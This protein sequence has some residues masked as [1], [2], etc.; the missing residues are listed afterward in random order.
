[1]LLLQFWLNLKLRTKGIFIVAVPA[2]ATVLIAGAAYVTGS[3]ADRAVYG[4]NQATEARAGIEELRAEEVDASAA[5]RG[6]L[7]AGD[8]RLDRR[9]GA[10]FAVFEAT[11]RRLEALISGQPAQQ[12][13]LDRI[14]ALQRAR[15]ETIVAAVA[16]YQSG[17]L[18]AEGQRNEVLTADNERSGMEALIGA[19]LDE[20]KRLL[21]ERVARVRELRFRSSAVIAGCGL[22][23]VAAGWAVWMLFASGITVRIRR[24]QENVDRLATGASLDPGPEGRDEIGLLSEGV[25][26]TVRTLKMKTGAL[27]NA[28]HGIAQANAAGAFVSVNKACAELLGLPNRAPAGNLLSRLRPE[29]RPAVEQAIAAMRQ[30]GRGEVEAKVLRADGSAADVTIVFLPVNAAD[31]NN[32]YHV[33]LRDITAQ[34]KAEQELI[35]ARDAALAGGRAKTQFLARISHDIRTPLN[36]ILGSADLLSQTSLGPDQRE[37]VSMF[38]RNCRRLVALINDFLDFSRIEA[39][40][41]RVERVPFRVRQIVDDIARTFNESASRKGVALNVDIAPAVPDRLSGD[42]LRIQQVL[43]NLASNALKFIREGRVDIR[44]R[45]AG[46]EPCRYVRF[47][48]ADTGPGI[49]PADQEK[50]FAAFTQLPNQGPDQLAGSGLGLTICRELLQTMGGEIGVESQPGQGSTFHFTVPLVLSQSLQTV[51]VSSDSPHA[52]A[53]RAGGPLR[54]L[55]AEDTEDNRTLLRHYLAG[56]PIEIEFAGNGA[57]ALEAVSRPGDFDLI[58]MD[59]DMPVLDGHDATRQIR[60]WEAASRRSPVPIVALSAHAIEEEV[61]ACLDDGCVAH[62]AKPVDQ[63]TLID[64]IERYARVPAAIVR[65]PVPKEVEQLVPEYLK[66]KRLQIEE[67]RAQLAGHNLDPIRRFG[68]NLKGTGRG[69]GFPQIEHAG[70]IIEKSAAE[71]DEAEIARQLSVLSRI[72]SESAVAV[73]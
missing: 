66:S 68:H 44:V 23:G 20:E 43:T 64:T 63:A 8:E 65:I 69:Y 60:Q 22:G 53:P 13:R 73:H 11:E 7:L 38:Q 70:R 42:P 18:S 52:V 30:T 2:A 46:V 26:Q 59:I 51:P 41:V 37:Y 15:I 16:R 40:A 34:K 32:G 57:E 50:I 3:F 25:A 21:D 67:V 58:L 36:A 10:S 5:V 35:C 14:A 55:I 33:F 31:R 28:L 47:E 19:M 39:G 49:T 71:S 1:M 4:I 54:I 45:V 24:L 48:V 62:V 9:I 61:R 6:Y 27:E 29:D 17:I 12:R 56:Q 72:V